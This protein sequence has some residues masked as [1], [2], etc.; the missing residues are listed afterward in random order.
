MGKWTEQSFFKEAKMTKK[1]KNEE[2][3]TIPNYKENA[4]Q[5]QIKILPHFY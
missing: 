4:N 5:I 1:K 3:L 2:M